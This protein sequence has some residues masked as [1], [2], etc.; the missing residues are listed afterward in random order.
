MRGNDELL[1]C[2]VPEPPRLRTFGVANKDALAGV[3]LECLPVLLAHKNVGQTAKRAEVRDV[4]FSTIAL[5]SGVGNAAVE[6]RSGHAVACVDECRDSM[7]PERW[8]ELGLDQEGSGTLGCCA[9]CAFRNT[10]LVWLVWLGVLPLD[11]VFSAEVGVLMPHVLAALVVACGLDAEAQAVLS[12]RLVR[13]ERSERIALA[14]EVGHD[15]EP[16]CVAD[17]HHPVDVPLRCSNR[18]SALEVCVDQGDGDEFSRGKARD[19]MA[20]ELAG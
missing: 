10:V 7:P 11:A 9:V 13:F 16:R 14:F 8:G 12:I 20:I 5:P 19:R 18:E 4:Q 3:R 17:K 15:P 1:R 2:G 6:R